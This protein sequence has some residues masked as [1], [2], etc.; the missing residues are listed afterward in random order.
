MIDYRRIFQVCMVVPD[1]DAATR[2]MGGPSGQT[3]AN[4][5]TYDNLVYWTPR[6]VVTTPRI[7]VTYSHQGPQH[8]ELIEP[9]P[10][11]FFDLSTPHG[12]HHVGLWSDTVGTETAALV[13]QGWTV[14]AAAV[15][16]DEGYGRVSF[17]RPPG[18]GTLL[19]IVST[20]IRPLMQGRVGKPLDGVTA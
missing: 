12:L 1:L 20:Q 17:V 19:E 6:G 9:S 3:F 8:V 11:G 14:E 10:G 4:P 7:R 18:G 16:P 15:S 2:A 5:W 13:A